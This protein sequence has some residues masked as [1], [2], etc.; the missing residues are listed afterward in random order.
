MLVTATMVCLHLCKGKH[1]KHYNL[2]IERKPRVLEFVAQ[3]GSAYRPSITVDEFK[4][5]VTYGK[6]AEKFYSNTTWN[7]T[8]ITLELAVKEVESL[9]S[10][11]EKKGYVN[12]LSSAYGGTYTWEALRSKSAPND[13]CEFH[14][15]SNIAVYNEPVTN[16]QA[17]RQPAAK[18]LP[19]AI[20]LTRSRRTLE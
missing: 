19:A 5:W 17:P 6:A 14:Y 16:P 2:W 3:A 15:R 18:V 12:V 10:K 9:V 8:S 7:S 1:D 4:I 11:L 13:I 20:T